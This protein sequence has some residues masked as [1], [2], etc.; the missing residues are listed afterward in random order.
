MILNTK[1]YNEVG[2]IIQ[3]TDPSNLS[4][5]YT[6]NNL[7]L[8]N[9]EKDRNGTAFTYQY[10]EQNRVTVQ[11]ATA[12]N[13]TNQTS[14]TIIGSSGIMTDTAETYKNGVQTATMQTGMDVL[15]RVTSITTSSTNYA[16]SLGLS[17][18]SNSRLTQQANNQSGFYVNYHYDR[19][20]M[21][22]V[23]M[24]GQSAVNASASANAVY[25]YEPNGQV[26]S[27]TYPTLADGSIL[28]TTNTYDSL[29]RLATVTNAKGNT[30]LSAYSYSYDDNNNMVS[31][32]ET[33]NQVTQTSSYT[34]DKLNRLLSMTRPGGSV[35]NYTYDVRGNRLTLQDSAMN[36]SLTDASYC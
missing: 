19:Q 11:S 33:V 8:L 20:R 35:V 12:V 16:S 24:D 1:Q 25:E 30:V 13:G 32:T 15:K 3:T 10:D 5:S 2:G 29:N 34:Y 27:I 22:Q 28:K 23:Q 17:Y 9:S 26:K 36:L 18:D 6:Y 14:R 21:D 4:T 31:K 7:G